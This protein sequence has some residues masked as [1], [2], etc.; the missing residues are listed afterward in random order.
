[1]EYAI[2]IIILLTVMALISYI[3]FRRSGDSDYESYLEYKYPDWLSSTILHYI[4]F[5][6]VIGIC[7]GVGIAVYFGGQ[8]VK[9][10]FQIL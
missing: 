1:M 5:V 4:S 9:L 2:F 3:G 7:I 8:L 6:S 10:I